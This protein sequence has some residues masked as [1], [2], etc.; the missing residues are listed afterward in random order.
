MNLA[1]LESRGVRLQEMKF[2]ILLFERELRMTWFSVE[3][4]ELAEAECGV[5]MEGEE[6]MLW[7]E[8]GLQRVFLPSYHHFAARP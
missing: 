8:L 2:S 6:V 3:N 7:L 4:Y 1:R 5:V